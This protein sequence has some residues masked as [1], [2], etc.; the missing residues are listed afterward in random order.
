MLS[1]ARE[2]PEA[3][4]RLLSENA[5]LCRTLGRR[6]RRSAPPFAV[7]CARGSSDAAATYAKYL[8]EIRLGVVTASV[9]PSVRSVYSSAPNMKG[10]LFLAVS[11]SGR[12]PDLLYLAE[13]AQSCGAITVALVNEFD[14]P[15]A[16]MCEVTLPLHAGVERSVAATKSWICS[17]AAILQLAAH[18]AEDQA[19]LETLERLPDDLARAA[20]IDWS[21]ARPAL[22]GVDQMYVVGRG[23]GLAA[24]QEAAL[25]LKETC[26]IHA[27]ALSAAE[28][29]H[30]PL[31]LAGPRFPVLLFGQQD[32]AFQS[33][34][35]LAAVLI[36]RDVPVIAAGPPLGGGCLGLPFDPGLTSFATPIALAQSF[37][38]LAEEVAR[39]RGRDPDAPPHLLKVTETV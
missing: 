8:L 28:A 4:A 14:S 31:T 26:G 22:A 19:L 37:Y 34:A 12:S 16:A 24:A 23:I 30:G 20:D 13:A 25:K 9:G 5:G 39:A 17:L 27:E 35:D 29:M 3:V 33:L 15:L 18:W 7:T 36:A 6:L 11:Q 10:A 21:A 38:P 1:E 2:A 32:E